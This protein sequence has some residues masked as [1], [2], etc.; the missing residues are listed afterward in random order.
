M[1]EE[2]EVT[3]KAKVKV[4][5]KVKV[6][7]KVGLSLCIIYLQTSFWHTVKR[8]ALKTKQHSKQT[9]ELFTAIENYL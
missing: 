1:V 9:T 4:N 6:K 2:V 5:V 7:V 3:V 8:G